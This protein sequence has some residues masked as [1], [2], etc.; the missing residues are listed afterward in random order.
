MATRELIGSTVAAKILG[1]TPRSV[2]RAAQRAGVGTTLP[3]PGG[4]V[5]TPTELESVRAELRAPGNPQFVPGNR[6]GQPPKK[7]RPRAKKS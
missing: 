7:R 6:F 2:V 4:L 5:L 3:R 1:C